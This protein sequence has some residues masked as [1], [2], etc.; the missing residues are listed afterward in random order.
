MHP[1]LGSLKLEPNPLDLE[2]EGKAVVVP[3]LP[4]VTTLKS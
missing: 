3:M 4:Q 2:V 1:S